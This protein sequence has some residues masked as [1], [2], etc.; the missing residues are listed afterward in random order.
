MADLSFD[1]RPQVV[2]ALIE[3]LPE[4]VFVATPDLRVQAVN[5]AAQR[6]LPALKKNEPL[7]RGL[8]APDVLDAVL[9]VFQTGQTQTVVWLDRFP[10]ER[11][12]EIHLSPCAVAERRAC[13]VTLR[14]VTEARRI[15][16]MRSDFVANASHELRTPLASL[17]GF[18]ETLQGPAKDDALA[19]E[20][21]LVI[22]SEQGRRMAR[23][24][25]DL[26]SLSRIEQN[27]HMRPDSPVDLTSIVSQMIDSLSALAEDN[28]VEIRF[29]PGEPVFVLGD[30]DELLRVAENLIE[31]AIK[32]GAPAP[33]DVTVDVKDGQG[34][35]VVVDH[36]P[37]VAAEHLPRLTER[38]YRV[39]AGASR[40]K[41]G[42]GL[43]LA[44]VK[45]I[46]ARHRGRLSIDSTLGEGSAFA[47]S[48]PLAPREEPA[49]SGS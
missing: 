39:D 47:V 11:H 46:V 3:A 15:D 12:F 4:A 27:L 20:K 42:T 35:L 1:Q 48:L 29:E 16:R 23:L 36:G 18:I 28:G 41:G 22:M 9:R 40:A 30:R 21:F 38:F 19:R 13:V 2:E 17:L 26:L 33:V 45:H 31:N 14:D 8:R 43:G 32:Y 49:G 10:V 34:R 24:V 25:D 44:L 7:V 6:L 37:G 5:A